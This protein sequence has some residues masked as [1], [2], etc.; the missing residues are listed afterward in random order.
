M[1]IG[2]LG[3]ISIVLVSS[4]C[5]MLKKADVVSPCGVDHYVELPVG[6]VITGVPLPTDEADKKYNIVTRHPGFWM[7]LPCHDLLEKGK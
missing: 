4:G 6:S 7:S 2:L 5:A 1:R 3:L